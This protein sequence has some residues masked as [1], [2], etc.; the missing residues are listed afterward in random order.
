MCYSKR[1]SA[2]TFV[3]NLFGSIAL[4]QL[5]SIST[6]Q[7]LAVFF[8]W[9]GLQQLYDWIFWTWSPPSQINSFVT[10]LAM[11]SNHL[12]PIVLFVVSEKQKQNLLSLGL[13]L[14]YTIYIAIYTA[15]IWSVVD[16]TEVTPSS[17]SS[18]EWKWNNQVGGGFVY[19][20]FMLSFLVQFL[21]GF[22]SPW[23]VL[24]C[25]FSLLSYL[26]AWF[27]WNK[28]HVVGRGWC[29]LGALGP[30]LVLTLDLLVFS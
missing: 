24:M 16:Y 10:K 2:V 29:W 13:L 23:N 19:F 26:I 21:I 18:L 12:Q 4:Y 30:G 1:V 7:R 14:L 9:I 15:R 11:I 3:F 28:Q 5:G 22:T 20:L 8:F 17:G 27:D 25:G 6:L